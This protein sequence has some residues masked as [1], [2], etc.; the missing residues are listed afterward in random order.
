MKRIT[1]PGNKR[2]FTQ[3]LNLHFQSRLSNAASS[4]FLI[5]PTASLFSLHFQ[6]KKKMEIFFVKK[7][8]K[9]AA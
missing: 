4:G 6:T 7:K 5:Q 1:Q 9:I 2:C 8:K 3:D